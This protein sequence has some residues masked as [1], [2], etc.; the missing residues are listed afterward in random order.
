VPNTKRAV[1]KK[2]RNAFIHR[3]QVIPD[4]IYLAKH[5]GVIGKAI[6]F[7]FYPLILLMQPNDKWNIHLFIPKWIK[8]LETD[9]I[10]PLPLSKKIL[11]FSAFRGQF[12]MNLIL[13]I[14]LVWRGHKVI[15]S[16]LPF[17]Q[18]PIKE[19]RH[20]DLSAEKYLEYALSSVER[21]SNGRIRCINLNGLINSPI[22]VDRKF[23]AKRAMYDAIMSLR[24]EKNDWN[25]PI[26]KKEVEHYERIGEKVQ[27]AVR[28]FFKNK[29]N[30]IDICIL[31]NGATFL[32]AHVLSICNEYTVPVNCFDKFSFR[33]VRNV[34]HGGNIRSFSDLDSIWEC[35]DKLGFGNSGISDAAINKTMD[36]L[37]QRRKGITT[38]WVTK[39]H[40][41]NNNEN[42][43]AN[44]L[45]FRDKKEY[46]LICPNVPFDAGYEELTSLF[47]SMRDWLVTTVR[48][49]IENTDKNI[50]IRGHPDEDR[51]RV[52]ETL[53]VILHQENID[54]KKLYIIPGKVKF[55]TY[56]VIDGMDC[57]IVF[58]STIGLEMA[59]LGKPVLVGSPIYY[60]RKGFTY[61]SDSVDG[62]LELLHDMV[63][64]TS[65]YKLSKNKIRNSKICHFLLHYGVQVPFPYDKPSGVERIPPQNIVKHESVKKYLSTFDS[66]S[67]TQ[68]EWLKAIH[69]YFSMDGDN[70]MAKAIK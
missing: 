1:Y 8:V 36:L 4:K 32:N 57:G 24:R 44:F 25:D 63:N 46:V 48:Y 7:L 13:A 12:Y 68:D 9:P 15:F 45:E 61:E 18:S 66:L 23:I 51:W 38:E 53:E 64:N 37:E 5:P 54:V 56:K 35:R 41:D 2:I 43:P 69:E 21:L 11:I 39:V 62:Y 20:D 22:R 60:S 52:E 26:Y 50:V 27:K 19:P 55:D 49:L 67:L 6:M 10:E 58:S 70:H 42:Y 28:S 29:A 16:Y 30:N 33:N 40:K 17:L 14:F 65:N 34:C 59:M 47:D 3:I 31:A